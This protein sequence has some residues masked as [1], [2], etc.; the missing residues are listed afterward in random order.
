MRAEFIAGKGED[1]GEVLPFQA[2][3]N[4]TLCSTA[5]SQSLQLLVLTTA[6]RILHA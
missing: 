1:A 6:A 2:F 4:G 3:Q 5:E